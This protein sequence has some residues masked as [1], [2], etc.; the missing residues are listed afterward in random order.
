MFS[1]DTLQTIPLWQVGM[2]SDDGL[3]AEK[4]SNRGV[5]TDIHMPG[6]VR[7][8]V[9]SIPYNELERIANNV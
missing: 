8:A 6:L 5:Y 7:A 1:N 4:V 3:F 2:P 9:I